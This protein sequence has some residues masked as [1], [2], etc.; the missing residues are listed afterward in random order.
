MTCLAWVAGIE[1]L[2]KE[3][4]LQNKVLD[5]Q[6]ICNAIESRELKEFETAL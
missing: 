6:Q 2:K 4:D 1:S 3:V 5:V